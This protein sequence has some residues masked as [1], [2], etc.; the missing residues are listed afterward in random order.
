MPQAIPTK[1]ITFPFP[2]EGVKNRSSRDGDDVRQ[3][4]KREVQSRNNQTDMISAILQLKQ[5]VDVMR[6]RILGGIGSGSGWVL[7]TPFAEADPTL[8]VSINTV[9]FIST[10]N[11]LQT[12]G[13]TDLVTN[14]NVIACSGFWLAKK[15]VPAAAGG[16]YNVPVFPYP[17]TTGIV[18]GSPGSLKGDLDGLDGSGNPAIFWV[19]LGAVVC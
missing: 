19:Y 3:A 10:G 15:N 2:H 14:A 18:T 8:N 12:E 5:K 9:V 16:K 7:Q 4:W 17:G 1:N 13:M 11:V 6:R